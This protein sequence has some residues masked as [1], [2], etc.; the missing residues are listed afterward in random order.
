MEGTLYTWAAEA[1]QALDLP[2]D[3]RWV[4]DRDVVQQVLDLAKE[5][6]QGSVR[7]AAPVGAFLA[8]V[9]VGLQHATDP[10]ALAQIRAQL[11][12]TLSE[13]EES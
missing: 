3:T 13:A 1:A 8:G 9:A 7:P 12:T 5:V 6:A 11:G 4:A 2:E 10:A